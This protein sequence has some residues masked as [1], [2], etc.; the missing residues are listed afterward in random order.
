MLR[1]FSLLCLLCLTTIGNAYGNAVIFGDSLSDE[2]NFYAATG[3]TIPPSPPYYEGRF[4]DGPVWPEYA[5]VSRQNFAYGGAMTGFTNL[6]ESDLPPNL[7]NQTGLQAQII[8]F[9][10]MPHIP[11]L[12]EDTLFIINIGGNDMFFAL[13]QPSITLDDLRNAA[14]KSVE[15]IRLAS[16]NLKAQGAKYIMVVGLPDL[17]LSP[18][19]QSLI[20]ENPDVEPVVEYI[21]RQFNTRLAIMAATNK[22]EFFRMKPFMY[23]IMENADA[24]GLTNLTDACL[25]NST[26]PPTVCDNPAEYFFWDGVHPTTRVHQIFANKLM[27][28]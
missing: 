19:I 14:I 10:Q 7:Q 18:W 17:T 2:G 28:E 16:L 9:E 5:Y 24:F 12:F 8:A 6:N 11:E 23:D 3:D 4:A 13:G 22:L 26:Q 15:N 27:E 25:D 1:L 20:E 21:T